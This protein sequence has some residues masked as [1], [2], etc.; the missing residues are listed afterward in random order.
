MYGIEG[1]EILKLNEH[2]AEAREGQIR[3]A[4]I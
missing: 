1:F 4:G 2:V 3:I